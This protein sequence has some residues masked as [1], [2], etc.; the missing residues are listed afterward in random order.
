MSLPQITTTLIT[1]DLI[2]EVHSA[3][4]DNIKYNKSLYAI[5]RTH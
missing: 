5:L 4:I 3:I 2:T 1:E